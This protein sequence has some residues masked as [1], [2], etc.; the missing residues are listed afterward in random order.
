MLLDLAPCSCLSD[1]LR[2]RVKARQSLL[3]ETSDGAGTG[4]YF[5]AIISHDVTEKL[6]PS[7]ESNQSVP[8]SISPSEAD[9]SRQ[10]K[11]PGA[12]VC[13]GIVKDKL[14]LFYTLDTLKALSW[15]LS[16][17]GNAGKWCILGVF[18]KWPQG[19]IEV[20]ADMVAKEQTIRKS[21]TANVSRG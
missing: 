17:P 18:G 2:A 4:T 8:A 21:V 19:A 1:R 10:G 15:R 16:W 20:Q 13:S 5:R 7:L 6:P 11:S 12:T 14:R 3:S 9:T